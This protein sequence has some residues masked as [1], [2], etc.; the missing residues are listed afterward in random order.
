[1]TGGWIWVAVGGFCGACLRYLIGVW[2]NK[3]I[4]STVPRATLFINLTGSFLLGFFVGRDM[5]TQLY[6]LLGTGFVGAYT[7]FST[8]NLECIQLIKKRE[9]RLL[10]FYVSGSYGLGILLA[11]LG[12]IIAISMKG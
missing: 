4:N 8:F 3:K 11:F 12:N 7:T 2:T 1:M 10:L 6:L 9:W 5:D